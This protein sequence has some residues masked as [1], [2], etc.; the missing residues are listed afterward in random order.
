[1]KF[2]RSK[3]GFTLVEII[4]VLVII[5]ILAAISLP[6]LTGYITDANQKAAISEARVVWTAMQTISSKMVGE[7][8]KITDI[9]KLLMDKDKG[10]EAIS[11][12]TGMDTD[13]IK[14]ITDVTISSAGTIDK[15][16][17]ASTPPIYYRDGG[18]F[19]TAS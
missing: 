8:G 13:K 10:K 2:L 17:Y 1:M 6:A 7:S 11:N 4:V 16:T 12:L 18:L 9:E 15:F 3:K 19:L 14:D 5:A